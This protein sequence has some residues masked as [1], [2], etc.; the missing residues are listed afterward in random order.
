MLKNEPI[1][2]SDAGGVGMSILFVY[3]RAGHGI[4]IGKDCNK[5][6]WALGPL[7]HTFK[8]VP[9]LL[10]SVIWVEKEADYLIKSHFLRG[11][12]R[13]RQKRVFGVQRI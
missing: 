8:G 10:N 3:S 1:T 4:R 2:C 6:S 5:V 9:V 11:S 13:K 7:P 12:V